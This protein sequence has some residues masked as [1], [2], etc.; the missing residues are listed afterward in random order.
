VLLDEEELCTPDEELL[1]DELLEVELLVDDPLDDELLVDDELPDD[2]P[3]CN[4]VDCEDGVSEAVLSPQPDS[5]SRSRLANATAIAPEILQLNV[6]TPQV[7]VCTDRV[8]M[9]PVAATCR[10]MGAD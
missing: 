1:D 9:C 10:R 7:Y 3:D 6:C 4:D 5:D 2:E 8:A